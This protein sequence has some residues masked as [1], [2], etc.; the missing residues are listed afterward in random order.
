MWSHA[1]A[2]IF[3]F[4]FSFDKKKHEAKKA[5]DCVDRK[6]DREKKK[7]SGGDAGAGDIPS[8]STLNFSPSYSESQLDCSLQIGRNGRHTGNTDCF[9]WTLV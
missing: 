6:R 2:L 7:M 4:P 3:F 8:Q 1:M 5:A 9:T